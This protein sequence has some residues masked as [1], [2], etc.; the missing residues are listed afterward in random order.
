MPIGD[1]RRVLFRSISETVHCLVTPRRKPMLPVI[2][3][4]QCVQQSHLLQILELMKR[5]CKLGAAHGGQNVGDKG[6]GY[7]PLP[8]PVA[9]PNRCVNVFR[10]EVYPLGGRGELNVDLWIEPMKRR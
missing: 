4:R 2:R 10:L 5:L 9:K 8:I 6:Q 3:A 7:Q 1:W